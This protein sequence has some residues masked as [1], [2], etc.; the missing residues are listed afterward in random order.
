MVVEQWSTLTWQLTMVSVS[1]SPSRMYY[2]LANSFATQL[3]YTF[4]YSEL[5]INL[6]ND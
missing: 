2:F 5:V 6:Q 3:P 4:D 1:L